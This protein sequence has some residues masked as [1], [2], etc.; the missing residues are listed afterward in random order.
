MIK[1]DFGVEVD[2][3]A[4]RKILNE[5]ARGP[6]SLPG[7]ARSTDN[8]QIDRKV[9]E[10]PLIDIMSINAHVVRLTKQLELVVT[11]IKK[12]SEFFGY[13]CTLP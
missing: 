10:I 2:K 1:R 4:T 5:M 7:E 3:A 12:D 9:F 6:I 11:R 13:H 8:E